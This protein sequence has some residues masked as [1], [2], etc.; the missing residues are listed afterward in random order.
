M[1]VTD[2]RKGGA[3]PY[4]WS[5]SGASSDFTS[6]TGSFS[7]S[8]LGW[9]PSV[10]DTASTT[11]TA[12]AAVASSA[13]GGAGLATSSVLATSTTASSATLGAGLELVVPTTT[14][15]GDYRATLTVTAIS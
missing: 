5:L 9:T 6:S 3:S 10:V 8:Y 1:L 2:T 15:S 7:G 11:V 13:T 4:T 14:A 12:G